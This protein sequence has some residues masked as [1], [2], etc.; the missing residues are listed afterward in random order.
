[1]LNLE[2]GNF[3]FR[4]QFGKFS[5]QSNENVAIYGYNEL[6]SYVRTPFLQFGVNVIDCLGF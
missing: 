5:P 4:D 6:A 2:G 1:M 3:H